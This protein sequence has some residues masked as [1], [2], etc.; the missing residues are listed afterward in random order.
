VRTLDQT[1]TDY[2]VEFVDTEGLA[3]LDA[4]F[5]E[6]F[7]ADEKDTRIVAGSDGYVSTSSTSFSFGYSPFESTEEPAAFAP[8]ETA[9]VS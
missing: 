4:L 2:E 5:E 9:H 8:S 6:E 3:R 1:P 7:R